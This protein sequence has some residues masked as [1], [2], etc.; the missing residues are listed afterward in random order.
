MTSTELSLTDKLEYS[1]VLSQ[2]NLLPKEYQNNPANVLVAIEYGQTVGISPI[3]AMNGVAVINGKP[4]AGA[5]LIGALVRRAGH[6]LR[7]QQKDDKRVR[8]SIVRAD[9][10]DFTFHADWDLER[11]KTAG[12]LDKT[13]PWKS[14]PMQMMTARAISEVARNA[15]PDVLLGIAYTAEEVESVDTPVPMEDATPVVQAPKIRPQHQPRVDE[16]TG[17]MEPVEAEFTDDPIEVM[18]PDKVAR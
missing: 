10:P 17:E 8:A 12:L 11:A 2:A 9:D 1:K 13:G 3:A 14:Y 4:T 15:C 7:V 18:D 6:K 16:A 5:Q